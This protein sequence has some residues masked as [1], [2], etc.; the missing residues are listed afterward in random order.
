MSLIISP[1]PPTSISGKFNHGPANSL[2]SDASDA[3]DDLRE[4]A[5][6]EVAVPRR[7]TCKCKKF[8]AVNLLCQPPGLE[9]CVC[10]SDIGDRSR[11]FFILFNNSNFIVQ[12]LDC[13]DW[14]TE[15]SPQILS[16]RILQDSGRFVFS[17]PNSGR[18]YNLQFFACWE[19]FFE[20]HIHL[21]L[22]NNQYG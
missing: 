6:L 10:S 17:F 5:R 8:N 14:L 4:E 12:F 20:F 16:P 3:R 9:V 7:C 21:F 18:R 19:L 22:Q 1:A 11:S 13:A 15:C 2:R